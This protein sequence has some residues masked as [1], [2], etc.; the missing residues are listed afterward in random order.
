MTEGLRDLIQR[1]VERAL[2]RRGWPRIGV[3]DSYDPN[4]HAVKIMF[5]DEEKLS[6][7]M[8]I[9]SA[10]TGNGWG[11][12]MAPVVGAQVVVSYH[13]GDTNAGFVSHQLFSRVDNPLPVPSGDMWLQHQ[14]GSALK[15][16][17]NGL[18]E[19][20]SANIQLGMKGA[21]FHQLVHDS[22]VE[23]FNNHTHSNVAPGSAVSGPPL[24]QLS[25]SELT[26]NVEAA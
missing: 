21:T 3:V 20:V 9:G 5:A 24:Q 17:A 18:V 11:L 10:W 25:Q 6:G 13:D 4:R 22:F 26:Q 2:R 19:L 1:E 8:P 7:W 16:H 12:H 15:L 23:L 14:N